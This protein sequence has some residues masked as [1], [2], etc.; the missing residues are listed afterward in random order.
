[1]KQIF[2]TLAVVG[3]VACQQDKPEI[4]IMGTPFNFSQP[5]GT[6]DSL[7]YS[8]YEFDQVDV[9][10]TDSNGISTEI[11]SLKE[12]NELLEYLESIPATHR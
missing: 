10:P 11:D 8:E 3:L 4:R 7:V 1:M 2:L 9:H 6:D 12:V 5:E